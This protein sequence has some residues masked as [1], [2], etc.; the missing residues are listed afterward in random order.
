MKVNAPD[1]DLQPPAPS[2]RWPAIALSLL[3]HG[4]LVL[5]LAWG[6]KWTR[7]DPMVA[8]S[9]EIWAPTAVEAAPAAAAP[10]EPA[11]PPPPAPDSKPAPAPPPAPS[12]RELA[13]QREAEIALEKRR[14]DEARK[15]IEQDKAQKEKLAQEKAEREKA[16]KEKAR[17]AERELAEKQKADKQKAEKARRDEERR[18]AEIRAQMRQEELRR[19]RQQQQQQNT[20]STPTSS[21]GTGS[22][23]SKGTAARAAAPS[24]SYAGLIVRQIRDNTKYTHP[25]T[26]Q[27]TVVVMVRT[28]PNG[29]I[30]E[31][32]IVTSSG[33][34]L[35]DEAV[36]RGIEKMGTVPKDID[37]NIPDVLLREGL[38]IKVAL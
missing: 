29:R 17:K 22:A 36:L 33:N 23:D 20:S 12:A 5:A 32:K 35:F 2:G 11:P 31:T 6:V 4:L 25:G 30:R 28:A 24:S 21:A 15:K 19:Q 18:D 26:D 27:P 9:A 10:P 3:A 13:Q 7:T 37:G 14:K 38:E 16:E 34:R 8:F 1:L